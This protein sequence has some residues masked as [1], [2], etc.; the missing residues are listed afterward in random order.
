MSSKGGGAGGD[1][2]VVSRRRAS[3]AVRGAAV[4][5]EGLATEPRGRRLAAAL[6]RR[7]AV[8][9]F[10]ALVVAFAGARFGFVVDCVAGFLLRVRTRAPRLAGAGFRLEVRAAL[11]AERAGFAGGRVRF[12]TLPALG[13]GAGR[14]ARRVR[15]D[16]RVAIARLAVAPGAVSRRTRRRVKTGVR[17]RR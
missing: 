7:T 10:F 11:L 6:V 1:G 12:A 2:G 17:L 3:V 8:A 4:R 14:E 9:D 13:L 16:V 5:R 15:W